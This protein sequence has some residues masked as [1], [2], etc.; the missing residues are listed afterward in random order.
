MAFAHVGKPPRH[1]VLRSMHGKLYHMGFRGF[2]TGRCERVESTRTS[3]RSHGTAVICP[4]PDRWDLDQTLYALDSQQSTSGRFRA[5]G[6]REDAQ[7]GNIPTFTALSK[8]TTS[9]SSRDP[10][11]G[12]FYVMDR[13]YVDFERLFVFTLCSSFFVVRTKK[14]L[15][16]NGATRTSTT[17]L[18]SI[19]T[20]Y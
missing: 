7:H 12:A 8:C 11:A 16:S 4:R 3:R 17:G 6:R 9:T 15:R 2:D 13:A 5:K 1:R 10:E 20:A 14:H 19:S 18:R